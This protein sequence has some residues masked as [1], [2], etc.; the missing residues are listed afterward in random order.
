M[1]INPFSD[2]LLSSYSY[3]KLFYS[4]YC[5]GWVNIFIKDDDSKIKLSYDTEG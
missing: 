1:L 2:E 5:M 4:P 3:K